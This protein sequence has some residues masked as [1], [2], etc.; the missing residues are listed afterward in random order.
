MVRK[1]PKSWRKN[2]PDCA[3]PPGDHMVF[4]V[5]FDTGTWDKPPLPEKGKS[6]EV[7]MSADLR[8]SGG[9]RRREGR[10]V[11]RERSRH[12]N[13]PIRFTDDMNKEDIS[14][15]S[16]DERRRRGS[17]DWDGGGSV[18]CRAGSGAGR[19]QGGGGGCGAAGGAVE[20]VRGGDGEEAAEDGDRATGA[21]HRRG[22]QGQGVRRGDQGHRP[23]DRLEGNIQGNKPEEKITRLEAEIAK[24]PTEM[25][26]VMEAILAHWYWQYFQQNR[27]RFMQRTAT[28]AAAGQGHPTWD[29]P[30][31]LAE[32]DK[33]FA[34]GPGGRGGAEEDAGG[35]VRRR[36]WSKGNVPDTYRPTLYDFLAYE[37]LK[38]Y[39]AGEQAGAKAEDAFEL[40]ADS[41]IFGAGRASSSSGTPKT[42]DERVA[43]GQGDPAVPG[44][45]EVPPARRGQDGVPRR[46][47]VAAEV[48]LQQG[49]G[50]G[51]ERALQ[52]GAEAVRGRCGPTTRFRPG[53]GSLGPRCCSRK[54]TWSR[55]TSWPSRG[56]RR[57]PS[58]FG[59]R[60]CFNLV[61][62]IE[63]KSVADRDRAGVERAVADDPGPLPQ[64]RPRSTSALCR[65][66][67]DRS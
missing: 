11:G 46:R 40:A 3:V 25:V 33:H 12:R 60:M 18:Q 9:W 36:C 2:Y 55:P 61:Q 49:G 15:D 27:W 66:G 51:E 24:A 43:D 53:P 14:E 58:S 28:A 39:T 23:E 5:S 1:V 8:D 64:R 42:T 30:R 31:I 41:P 16:G 26:P 34:A 29:L 45:A 22:D 50:R 32:I 35:P 4:E 52:G 37:A 57:F 21:D 67:L 13:W 62:Q 47:P 59:G 19:G 7:K 63:A 44:A 65:D 54:A 56:R 6:R 38:F 48:R 20:A 10:R 17:L